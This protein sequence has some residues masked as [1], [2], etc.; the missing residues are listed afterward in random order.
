MTLMNGATSTNMFL[1]R[2]SVRLI[3]TLSFGRM[4][5]VILC[6]FLPSSFVLLIFSGLSLKWHRFRFVKSSTNIISTEFRSFVFASFVCRRCVQFYVMSCIRTA[7]S[8]FSSAR[9]IEF[10]TESHKFIRLFA[11]CRFDSLLTLA[12]CDIVIRKVSKVKRYFVSFTWNSTE[13]I[14]KDM[15]W[16]CARVNTRIREFHIWN[17]SVSGHFSLIA[18]TDPSIDI[19]YK[20]TKNERQWKNDY[21]RLFFRRRFFISTASNRDSVKIASF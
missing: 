6:V 9:I 1:V 16:P 10:V 17:G 5:L 2:R 3:L 19:N 15:L 8:I 12:V 20:T 7:E 18:L 4:M 11:L 13:M 21:L 14:R